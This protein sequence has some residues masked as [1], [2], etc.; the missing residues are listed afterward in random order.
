MPLEYFKYT[1]I[2]I[3]NNIHSCYWC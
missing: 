3:H 2:I 1:L